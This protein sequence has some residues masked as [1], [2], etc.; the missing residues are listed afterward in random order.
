M[1]STKHTHGFRRAV[2]AATLAGL[3]LTGSSGC[4]ERYDS[5][6]LTLRNGYFE[7]LYRPQ[8][9]GVQLADTLHAGEATPEAAVERGSYAF[10][11]ETAS[12]LRLNADVQLKGTT[13]RVRLVVNE[14]GRL[15]KE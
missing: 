5:Y 3:A 6:A 7:A 11:V 10:S 2:T 14:Q 13:Q 9:G 1:I 12:G 15:L 4:A 8:V